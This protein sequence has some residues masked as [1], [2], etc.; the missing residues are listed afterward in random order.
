[1]TATLDLEIASPS[2]LG[3]EVT[4]SPRRSRSR[5][6]ASVPGPAAPAGREGGGTPVLRIRPVPRSEPL[7]D[8]ERVAGL[9][10]APGRPLAPLVTRRLP[11]DLAT[12]VRVRRAPGERGTS[13]GPGAAAEAGT[14][15]DARPGS[16]SR[17]RPAGPGGDGSPAGGPSGDGD[18]DGGA[19]GRRRPAAPTVLRTPEA[20]MA[21]VATPLHTSPPAGRSRARSATRRRPGSDDRLAETQRPEAATPTPVA[22]PVL[23]MVAAPGLGLAPADT[24]APVPSA[25]LR[26]TAR[27]LLGTCMEVL[28]GFRPL[29]QLRPYCAPERFEAIVNRLLR[30]IY[31][32]RGYGAT[33]SSLIAGRESSGRPGRPTRV[34]PEDR[35]LIRRVQICGIMEDVAELAVVMSRRNKVWAMT[36]RLE[37]SRGRWLCMHLEVL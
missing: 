26:L 27:R 8:E 31:G 20:V 3:D 10:G 19:G 30:P 5:V 35:L 18:L 2:P 29:A 9:S 23:S 33:R 12:G 37:R 1:V 25:E 11:L 13:G 28:G 24:P 32:G 6:R 16:P 14:A 15:G 7:T 21:L 22:A 36:V 4:A 34:G 17:P